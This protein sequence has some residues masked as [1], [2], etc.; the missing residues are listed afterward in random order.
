MGVK[1]EGE[2]EREER[3]RGFVVCLCCCI[4]YEVNVQLSLLYF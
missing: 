3:E 2:C 4:V 1:R